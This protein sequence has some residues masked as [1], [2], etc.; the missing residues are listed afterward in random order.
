MV[1]VLEDARSALRSLGGERS[2]PRYM[3]G[4]SEAMMASVKLHH[5]ESDQDFADVHA[6]A[7]AELGPGLASLAE[8]K[9]VD[10]MTN[11]A[12]WVV[13]RNGAVTGFL[14]PLALTSAGVA[15]LVCQGVRR[16]G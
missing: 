9:R 10:G 4:A 14:A 15:A 13:R 1:M 6:L 8:I 3:P 16:S 5:A 7:V 2:H 11:A 12:I